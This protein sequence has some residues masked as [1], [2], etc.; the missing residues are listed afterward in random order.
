M[1]L[2]ARAALDTCPQYLWTGTDLTTHMLHLLNTPR[3][4]HDLGKDH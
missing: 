4:Q 1:V 3:G 2:L